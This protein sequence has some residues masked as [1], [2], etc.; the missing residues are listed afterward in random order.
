MFLFHY[1]RRPYVLPGKISQRQSSAAAQVAPKSNGSIIFFAMCAAASLGTKTPNMKAAVS[2]PPTIS[3]SRKLQLK[4]SCKNFALCRHHRFWLSQLFFNLTPI[5]D[6]KHDDNRQISNPPHTSYLT[7]IAIM[8]HES[9]WFSRPRG[10]G[11]GARECRV[12][13]HPAGLIRKYGLN[14]CRQCFRERSTDIG[15]TK[16][17]FTSMEAKRIETTGLQHF[18]RTPRSRMCGRSR[19]GHF[20][21]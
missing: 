21:H 4:S 16:I 6:D 9:V 2:N 8:S 11:K 10:Y 7:L 14:I 3:S 18:E 13:T 19:H 15:F 1:I 5:T 20:T 17:D 12:C